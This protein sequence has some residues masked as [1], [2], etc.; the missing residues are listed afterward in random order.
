M[1]IMLVDLK[2]L[3]HPG[4]LTAKPEAARKRTRTKTRADRRARETASPPANPPS[5]RRQ[6]EAR[7]VATHAVARRPRAST[8]QSNLKRRKIGQSRLVRSRRRGVSLVLIK[9]RGVM[10][11]MCRIHGRR[12]SN[13]RCPRSDGLQQ[14]HEIASR[15]PRQIEIV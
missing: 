15:L 2:K 9:S 4:H 7:R 1:R 8:S 14:N 13:L 6:R 11:V 5:L 12:R 3:L 10:C